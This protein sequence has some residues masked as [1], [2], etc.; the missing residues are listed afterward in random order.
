MNRYGISL[1]PLIYGS[2]SPGPYTASVKNKDLRTIAPFK[3]MVVAN[4]TYITVMI[5]RLMRKNS[6]AMPKIKYKTQQYSRTFGGAT[7]YFALMGLET[8]SSRTSSG[9]S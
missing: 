6:A 5:I 7:S 4:R 9:G 8:G 2:I 1:S 3:V